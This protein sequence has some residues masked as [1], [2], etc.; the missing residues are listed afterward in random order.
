M[1]IWNFNPF[2]IFTGNTH[3][4]IQNAATFIAAAMDSIEQENNHRVTTSCLKTMRVGSPST[5]QVAY[6][7]FSIAMGDTS[8]N[9][10]VNRA[11]EKGTVNLFASIGC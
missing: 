9:V 1:K 3:L 5:Q 4:L 2:P 10:C 11:A 8:F 7:S 6:L